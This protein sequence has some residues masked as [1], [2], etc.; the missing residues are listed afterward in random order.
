ML[1][2]RGF[3][4]GLYGHVDVL[5][6]NK[7]SMQPQLLP[8]TLTF[9]VYEDE[10]VSKECLPWNVLSNSVLSFARGIASEDIDR[11]NA[12]RH[13]ESETNLQR[14]DVLQAT[15]W[16]HS[17]TAHSPGIVWKMIESRSYGWL[18]CFRKQMLSNFV[19]S[20]RPF[21][22]CKRLSHPKRLTQCCPPRLQ[23][24]ICLTPQ[25][26]GPSFNDLQWNVSRHNLTPI[27]PVFND[28]DAKHEPWPET[29]RN[30]WTHWTSMW[31]L[32][33]MAMALF[34]Q[35]QQCNFSRPIR[36]QFLWKDGR[37]ILTLKA[38]LRISLVMVWNHLESTC[39]VSASN[40]Q[41]LE[42]GARLGQ[43]CRYKRERTKTKRSSRWSLCR[44]V[45]TCKMPGRRS[46]GSWWSRQPCVSALV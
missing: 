32:T 29:W 23:R 22:L 30:Q 10:E 18:C 5:S 38:S 36:L 45:C 43:L 7:S 27:E 16:M 6:I 41:R 3:Q 26:S 4:Q 20:K 28:D 40:P 13:H 42:Q 15:Y 11:P 34:F 9:L 19:T 37:E 8:G 14:E 31:N 24:V 2:L 44:K 1:K 17:I 35:Y 46:S 39:N 12:W 33:D 25:G 21:P